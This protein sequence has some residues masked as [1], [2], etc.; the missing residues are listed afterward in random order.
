MDSSAYAKGGTSGMKTYDVISVNP[1][2]ERSAIHYTEEYISQMTF[3]T[4][5]KW[6]EWYKKYSLLMGFGVRRE[7]TRTNRNGEVI[8]RKWVCSRE[9]F[10]RKS[11]EEP[12]SQRQERSI[13]RCGCGAFLRVK[14]DNHSKT[15]VVTNLKLA[16]NHDTTDAHQTFFIPAHRSLSEG[17]KAQVQSLCQTGIKQTQIYEQLAH[18]AG[19]YNRLPCTKK[20]LYN[21]SYANRQR[22]I[23]DGDAESAFRYLQGIHSKEPDFYFAMETD[24]DD[25][26][27]S[28]FWSDSTARLDY[29]CFGDVLAFDST[30]KTNRYN[31]PFVLLVGVNHHHQTIIFGSALLSGETEEAYT[32]LLQ[33][34]HEGMNNKSPV[35]VVT[36]GD[37]AMRNAIRK[38]FPNANHRLCSWHLARNATSHFT[39]KAIIRAF[40]KCMHTI[41]TRE[42][43]EENWNSMIE[44]FDL[45]GNE[46]LRKMYTSRAMWAEAYLRG[47]FWAELR[48]TQRCEGMNASMKRSLQDKLPLVE[49]MQQY[50]KKL[51][52]MRHAEANQE[53]ITHHTSP[54][55][56]NTP[57]P[58]IERHAQTIYTRNSFDKIVSRMKEEANLFQT[59][60]TWSS[61]HP[62]RIY[63]LETTHNPKL[64]WDVTFDPNNVAMGCTCLEFETVGLP[65]EHTFHIM[66]VERLREIPQNLISL[67][68]SRIAKSNTRPTYY[69]L[70]EPSDITEVARYGALTSRCNNLCYIASRSDEAYRQF[71]D[72]LDMVTQKMGGLHASNID[73]NCEG[74]E[75]S[76]GSPHILKDPLVAQ[77][78]GGHNTDKGKQIKKR[79]CG[80]C[81]E[82]GHTKRTCHLLNINVMDNNIH[83][84]SPTLPLSTEEMS[85]YP[86]MYNTYYNTSVYGPNSLNPSY[87]TYTDA[88]VN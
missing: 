70:R 59:G 51:D 26:L 8:M 19:G 2:N 64:S 16:H 62:H 83:L 77:T 17:E 27:Q 58:D 80:L 37:K 81:K 33:S 78:K 34:F 82:E 57:L 60:V 42:Q 63:T 12:G 13:I 55:P 30:Y 21:Y 53:Y 22:K 36:D 29:A 39:N 4:C 46:W 28:L 18:Q 56:A 38:V 47:Q 86:P 75:G 35:S 25:R 61:E 43:F 54:P 84:S 7:D 72:E 31:L 48:S 67:R 49:F 88:Q 1:T 52:G 24:E 65:C 6:E 68:W 23:G 73:Q 3:D 71:N 76:S 14:L 32:W 9:G 45:K 11:N 74:I 20:D 50:H 85:I 44:K 5:E 41:Q 40:T 66:K 87:T 15:W 79:K 69:S 10:K